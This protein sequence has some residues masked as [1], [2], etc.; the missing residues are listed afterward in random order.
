MME[1]QMPDIDELRRTYRGFSGARLIQIAVSEAADLLP[2]AAEVLQE[3]LRQRGYTSAGA[4]VA[5]PLYEVG[6][7]ERLVSRIR[8]M[9]C[10][11]CGD[12]G[13]PLNGFEIETVRGFLFIP[14]VMVRLVLGCPDCII[15]AARNATRHTLA[16]GMFALSFFPVLTACAKNSRAG[17]LREHAEPTQHLLE[18]AAGNP[19]AIAFLLQRK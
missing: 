17:K 12:S 1:L 13:T 19:G 11:L 10:P 16:S 6:P 15:E 2:E 8:Q 4:A 3:E 7:M 18:Y 9:P 14:V 5:N